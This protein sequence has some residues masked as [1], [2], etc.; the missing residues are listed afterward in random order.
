[1]FNVFAKSK[2]YFDIARLISNYEKMFI[3]VWYIIDENFEICRFLIAINRFEDMLEQDPNNFHIDS[4]FL[5]GNMRVLQNRF[6]LA[7]K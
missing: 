4:F 7:A 6:S 2:V 3:S 1:M 5:P